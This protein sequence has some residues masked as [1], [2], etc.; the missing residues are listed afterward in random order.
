ME[1]IEQHGPPGTK[2]KLSSFSPSVKEGFE[3][4]CI[5][6]EGE[7]YVSELIEGSQHKFL[8]KH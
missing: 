8:Q 1:D 3:Q 6:L 4:P 2:V 7:T 5:E